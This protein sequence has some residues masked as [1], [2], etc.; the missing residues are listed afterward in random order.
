MFK[1]G[2]QRD[3]LLAAHHAFV[4]TEPPL[5]QKGNTQAEEVPDQPLLRGRPSLIAPMVVTP[6]EAKT[7]AT[8]PRSTPMAALVC[9]VYGDS[10]CRSILARDDGRMSE[11]VLHFLG[12]APQLSTLRTYFPCLAYCQVWIVLLW[13][14]ML[15]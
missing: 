9:Q 7:L 11:T 3:L 2:S 15:T 8:V 10:E 6:A 5:P 1:V 4:G 12:A 14:M 13:I